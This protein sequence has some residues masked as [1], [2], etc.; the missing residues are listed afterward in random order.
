MIRFFK[1]AAVFLISSASTLFAQEFETGEVDREHARVELVSEIDQ[2]A[3]GDTF[4]V[5][6]RFDMIDHWHL[7]WTNPGDTGMPPSVEWI[8]PEGVTVGELEFPTPERILTEPFV[9]YA[10][11]G[12]VFFLSK[13]S[14]G[15]DVDVSNGLRIQVVANWLAC[16]DICVPGDANLQL[17]ITGGENSSESKWSDV[18]SETRASQAQP[19]AAGMQFEVLENSISLSINW[20]GLEGESFEDLYFYAEQEG[21]V[22]SAKKQTYSQNGSTVIISLPKS[23]YFSGSVEK[24]S[25][26][27]YNKSGFSAVGGSQAIF[28][29]SEMEAGSIVEAT[30]SIEATSASPENESDL[31][32]GKALVFAFLGGLILNLMPCVFPI[33]SIKIMG[34]VQQSGED[35]KKV[36]SHGLAFTVGVLVSFWALAGTLI[37][38]RS[39]GDRLG[40]GFQLQSPEFVAVLLVIMFVFGLSL[41]GVFEFGTS[42]IG[43]ASKVKG[44]GYGSSFFSGVLATAVATPCTGPFMGPALAFALSLSALQSLTVF[45]VLALGMAA[46]YLILSANPK[47]V[48][49]LPRPGAWMETF[50]QAMAFPMFATCVWL[51]WLMGAHVG[52]DGLAGVLGGLLILSIAAWAYGKWSAP[53][54]KPTTRRVSMIVSLVIAVAGLWMLYPKSSD[55]EGTVATSGAKSADKYGLVWE[56]FSPELVASLRAEGKPVYIDFTAKWCLTCKANKTVVFNS[57][58]V[59]DRFEELGVVLVKADW[60]KRDPVITDALESF[61]RSGVPLNV[62]Y[63]GTENGEP[64]LLPE[65][66]KPSIVLDAL[67]KI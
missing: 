66:L 1:L 49:A 67:D 22:D 19:I 5:A 45:S 4:D 48:E 17:D 13:V 61:K 50:K 34:F 42:A 52:V 65:L 21:V 8:V 59:K 46:P 16:A 41:M 6:L 64:L 11:E 24:L 27:L 57:E 40:W 62:L 33:L 55:T 38:L 12:E 15:E 32:L 2:V 3:T 28:V 60:T 10:Y 47:L 56:T 18:I 63:T 43:L 14:V 37:A 51:V 30:S 36:F 58:E 44:S 20:A 29:D 54:R 7:Y 9:S 25:G 53:H 39:T 26:I 23:E 31:T 35:K